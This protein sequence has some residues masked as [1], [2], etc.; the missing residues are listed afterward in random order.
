MHIDRYLMHETAWHT[1]AWADAAGHKNP[2][3]A[4]P[5]IPPII[6]NPPSPLSR[7]IQIPPPIDPLEAP[8]PGPPV[9]PPGIPVMRM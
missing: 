2:P 5:A 4:P 8:P 6:I 3:S 9:L 1:T 7:I